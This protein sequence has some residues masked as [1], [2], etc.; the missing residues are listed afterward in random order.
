LSQ[1]AE[2]FPAPEVSLYFRPEDL[3]HSELGALA[4]SQEA[5]DDP[6]HAIHHALLASHLWMTRNLTEE[7]IKGTV[8]YDQ[9]GIAVA[10]DTLWQLYLPVFQRVTGPALASTYFRAMAQAKAGD[11]DQALIY[12]LANE[13]AARMGNYFHETSRDAMVQGFNSFVNRKVPARAAAERV[14]AAYGLTPK[15]MSGYVALEP[16]KAVKTSITQDLKMK[17]KAYVA[18]SIRQRLKVFSLQED[19]NLEQQA[20]QFVWMWMVEHGQMDERTEKVWFTAKDERVCPICGPLHGVAVPVTEQFVTE[21][22]KFWV[23]G[24]HVN[25]RCWVKTRVPRRVLESVTK[26]DD[27][28]WNPREHPRGGNPRNRG[29]FSRRPSRPFAEPEPQIAIP[30]LE[31]ILRDLESRTEEVTPDLETPQPARLVSRRPAESRPARL[32]PIAAPEE[33]AAEP[34]RVTPEP[35]RIQPTQA[36]LRAPEARVQAE[37]TA[38]PARLQTPVGFTGQP[39]VQPEPKPRPKPIPMVV[40]LHEPIYAMLTPDDMTMFQQTGHMHFTHDRV[41]VPDE[42]KVVAEAAQLRENTKQDIV[43]RVTQHREV[44]NNIHLR[45]RKSGELVQVRVYPSDVDQIADICAAIASGE[46]EEDSAG[47][48][49]LLDEFDAN[50]IYMTSR[51]YHAVEAAGSLS[52]SFGPEDLK[53]GIMKIESAHESQRGAVNYEAGTRYGMERITLGG[54][55]RADLTQENEVEGAAIGGQQARGN[56]IPIFDLEPY[57]PELYY[58]EDDR[59]RDDW[60]E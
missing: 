13:H 50:D 43:D 46:M 12:A 32:R 22:G 45:D 47:A 4:L 51:K 55:Y 54:Q 10:A 30:G 24:V 36:R 19:H 20:N 38:R 27:D 57:D 5:K 16:Q 25:C 60:N 35:A 34:A 17:L 2:E 40:P 42:L 37:P 48:Y 41:F 58:P 7:F 31:E 29:Q 14:M 33:P 18:S 56:R 44:T 9:S 15:Q 53:V 59:P 39:R 26:A 3:T 52:P 28:E 23:P 1:A 8:A 21:D 11:I 6:K 49:V